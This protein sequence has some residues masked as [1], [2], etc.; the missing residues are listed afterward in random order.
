VG[1]QAAQIL[2]M[3]FTHLSYTQYSYTQ[4]A[5]CSGPL[6]QKRP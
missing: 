4:L 5:H 2:R 6:A 3:A 1:Y